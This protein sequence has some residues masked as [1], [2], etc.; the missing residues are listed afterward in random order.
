VQGKDGVG[1]ERMM[2][3]AAAERVRS[4]AALR[5]RLREEPGGEGEPDP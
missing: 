1:E 4:A 2:D 5:R 3:G